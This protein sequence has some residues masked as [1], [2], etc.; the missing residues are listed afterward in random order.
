VQTTAASNGNITLSANGSAG[1]VLTIAAG[2]AGQI[3][4]NAGTLTAP[5]INLSSGSGDIGTSAAPIQTAAGS[6]LSANSNGNVYLNQT[7]AVQIGASHAGAGQAFQLTSSAA[8]TTSGTITG[9]TISFSNGT[10][11]ITVGSNV[12]ASGL[13]TLAGGV[14]TVTGNLSSTGADVVID[15]NTVTV[16]GAV[17]SVGNN[18]QIAGTGNLTISGNGSLSAGGT[19]MITAPAGSTITLSGSLTS[20]GTTTFATTTGTGAL[21]VTN[22][23]SFDNA[24]T[25]ALST[26]GGAIRLV[27]NGLFSAGNGQLNIAGD[28]A[29]TISSGN[30][31]SSLKATG[32][33]NVSSSGASVS[34][35]QGSVDSSSVIGGSAAGSFNVTTTGAGLVSVGGIAAQNTV[36]VDAQAG[37]VNVAG[38]IAAGADATISAQLN[39]TVAAGNDVSAGTLTGAAASN[40]FSTNLSDYDS[41]GIAVPGDVTITATAGSITLNNGSQLFSAGGSTRINAAQN[42]TTNSATLFAQG[43]NIGVNALNG[44]LNMTGGSITAV[45]RLVAGAAPVVIDNQSVPAYRGGSVVLWSGSNVNFNSTWSADANGRV[46]NGT[47][48]HIDTAATTTGSGFQYATGSGYISLVVTGGGSLSVTGSTLDANGGTI[49]IDPTNTGI[50]G[51][52]ILAVAPAL[53]GAPP[54]PPPPPVSAPPP[55]GVI[56][57]PPPPL[58]TTV[59]LSTPTPGLGQT[60]LPP[61]ATILPT[62]ST[63]ETTSAAVPAGFTPVV[64]TSCIPVPMTAETEGAEAWSVAAGS[65]QSFAFAS[66]D[67]T[68]V[69]GSGGTAVAQSGPNQL[70]LKKGK[71]VVVAGTNGLAVRTEKGTVNLP[72]SSSAVIDRQRPGVLRV[73]CLTGSGATI[74]VGGG[75]QGKTMSAGEGQELVIA[76]DGTSDE[77]L[78]LVDGV[79]RVSIEATIKIADVWIQKNKFD[80]RLFAEKE[81]LINCMYGCVPVHVRNQLKKLKAAMDGTKPASVTPAPAAGGKANVSLAPAPSVSAN[82]YRPIAQVSGAASSLPPG[83]NTVGT[84]SASVRY[85]KSSRLSFANDST[86]KLSSGDVVVAADRATTVLCGESRIELAAGA[87]AVIKRD[88]ADSVSVATLWQDKTGDVR[89]IVGNH[90]VPVAAGCELLSCKNARAFDTRMARD[91]VGR[92]RIHTSELPGGTAVM[93][94]EVSFVS[95]V[96]ASPALARIFN[97]EN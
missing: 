12:T 23:G 84:G 64:M 46:S 25:I 87:V 58:D 90:T 71:V 52:S 81:T 77:E 43:G 56:P 27:N 47:N 94:S 83:L 26:T 6:V 10:Q 79:E 3:V 82:H 13:L 48:S 41:T 1:S 88:D 9:G 22:N 24:G 28:Q 2:G 60:I 39:V 33:I 69:T 35:T 85:L 18:V 86:I 93:L 80:R 45:A 78:I 32:G 51:V 57:L 89:A 20:S 62:D 61:A 31:T 76:D 34:I 30:T 11:P 74:S 37:S 95:M 36:D 44:A 68:S 40:P 91:Y 54:P 67:G 42:V 49:N 96:G 72:A 17:G 97:S 92:R 73:E 50:A 53:T 21:N 75:K 15:A 38:S 66:K 14:T 4:R 59:T 5:T 63:K 16:N 29:V 19:N 70:D 7:G 65:C 55:V 8:I